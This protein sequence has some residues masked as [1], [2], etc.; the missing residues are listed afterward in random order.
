MLF[1]SILSLSPLTLKVLKLP[2]IDEDSFPDVVKSFVIPTKLLYLNIQFSSYKIIDYLTQIFPKKFPEVLKKIFSPYSI[3]FQPT[4]NQI[5]PK[6][7]I[8]S[9]N[10]RDQ[11]MDEK[12]DNMDDSSTPF[13]TFYRPS[14]CLD[15]SSQILGD[16]LRHIMQCQL[17]LRFKFITI[18]FFDIPYFFD[19]LTEEEFNNIHQYSNIRVLRK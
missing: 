8:L 1:D 17:H 13:L 18:R 6:E 3:W 2:M 15:I 4:T 12:K 7:E 16:L 9:E 5:Q 10:E 14:R 11:P 19:E